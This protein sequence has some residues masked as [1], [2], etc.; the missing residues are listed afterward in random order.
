MQIHTLNQSEQ[1]ASTAFR[2]KGLQGYS[3]KTYLLPILN[4]FEARKTAGNMILDLEKYNLL[5]FNIKNN[6]CS[7]LNLQSGS[8]TPNKGELDI[9]YEIRRSNTIHKSK[10]VVEEYH[11]K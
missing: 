1:V 7:L 10:I 8:M 6:S 3:Y 4:R 9:T 5:S 11:L 2:E